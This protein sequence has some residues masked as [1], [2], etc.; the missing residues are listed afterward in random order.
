M[1]RAFLFLVFI[2][3]I[4]ASANEVFLLKDGDRISGTFQNF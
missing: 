1:K 3:L 2:A 4:C